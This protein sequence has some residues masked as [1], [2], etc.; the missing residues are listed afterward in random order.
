MFIDASAQMSPSGQMSPG[1]GRRFDFQDQ[2]CICGLP[3]APNSDSCDSC[4]GKNSVHHEG[5]ILKKQKRGGNL[6]K[7]W[8]VL[9]GKELYSYKN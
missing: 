9:L 3:C 4:E 2:Y 8:F 5:E 7:Y 6:K 1:V